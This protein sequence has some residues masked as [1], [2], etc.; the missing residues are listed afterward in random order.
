[1]N[2]KET[3][4]ADPDRQTQHHRLLSIATTA[5]ISTALLLIVAKLSAWF[6]TGSL[7]LLATLLDSVMDAVASIITM[8]AIRVAITP[9]DDD[10]HFGHGKAEQLAVLAQSAF[11]TGSAVVLLLSAI[12]RILGVPA[13]LGNEK[14][15][16]AVMII[17]I[18]ATSFLLMIQSYVIRKTRS[19]AIAADSLH[20]KVDLLTNLAV[21]MA[22]AGSQLG[23]YQLDNGL[24][25]IISAYMLY[26]VKNMAWE[27]IQQ[28]MDQSLPPEQQQDIERRV[29]AV[30][31]V[32]GLHELR[33]RVSGSTPF[34]QLHLDLDGTLT[35][36][37]AHDI[38]VLAKQ[39][40]LEA[41]PDADVIIHL[42]PD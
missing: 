38:G 23:Y 35:L 18:I 16:I 21:I 30:E 40:L 36:Q 24:A 33:T 3:R 22:L 39:A 4:H 8:I 42:D 17:S 28:L 12:D 1:M 41:M 5:S 37:Q 11:I 34:I 25:I 9:A 19:V 10:H 31:G 27:A 7:S 32:K 2:Y 20:Y 13:P 15:G 26:S 14:I 6:F 29:L